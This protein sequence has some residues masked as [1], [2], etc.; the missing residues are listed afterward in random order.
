MQY[1]NKNTTNY[2]VRFR[3]AQKFNE[4]CNRSLITKGIQEYGMK[5]LFLFQ[6]TGSDSPK[7]DK[8]KEAEKSGEEIL[9]AILYLKKIWQSQACQP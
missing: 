5:I 4:A 9:C 1:A 7:E 6:N 2:L 8:K 3:N